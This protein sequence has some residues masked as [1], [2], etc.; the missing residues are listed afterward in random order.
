VQQYLALRQEQ[1]EVLTSDR[2]LVL[3]HHVL[4]HGQRLTYHGIYFAIEKI[5][6]LAK[7]PSYTRIPFVTVLLL[8]FCCRELI[9]LMHGD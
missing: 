2:P 3:S 7:I 5:G 1:G 8:S 6:E 9:L 4:R